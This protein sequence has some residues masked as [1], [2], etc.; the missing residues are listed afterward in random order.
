MALGADSPLLPSAVFN[1]QMCDCLP[2][3]SVILFQDPFEI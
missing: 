1:S 2:A 3:S